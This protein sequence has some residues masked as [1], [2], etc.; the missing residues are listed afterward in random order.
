MS[1]KLTTLDFIERA[2]EAHGD[3]YDYSK[4]IY[5][6]AKSKLIIICP[7]HGEFEQD[8]YSHTKGSGCPNCKSK[9]LSEA[10]LLSQNEII[11]KF[12]AAHG[13]RYDYSQVNYLGAKEKVT[14]I[15][16][17]HGPFQQLPRSHARGRSCPKCKGGVAI[18][19]HEFIRRSRLAH[20]DFYDY[21]LVNYKRSANKVT[22]ICPEH[23]PF[24]Q[25]ASSHMQG[26][27][28]AK[29]RNDKARKSTEKFI[30][31][32]RKVHGDLYDYRL[33]DYHLSSE[34]I[35]IIC[36]RH[37][38][39]TQTPNSHLRGSGCI[40]CVGLEKRSTNSFIEEA[41]DVHGDRYD[42]S[43]VDYINSYTPVS[44]ICKEHGPFEQTPSRH[45]ASV[46]GCAKCAI[47]SRTQQNSLTKEQFIAKARAVHGEKYDYSKVKYINSS[48]KVTIICPDHGPFEQTPDIHLR[49]SQCSYCAGVRRNADDF[50]KLASDVH[51]NA[52]DYS[53]VRYKDS[54]TK[55]VIICPKH[56]K[57]EQSPGNHLS[58]NG[59]P[60]CAMEHRAIALRKWATAE[61]F[62]EAAKAV[63]GNQYDYSEVE[64]ID[65]KTN[66]LIRCPE[67]GAFEQLPSVHIRGSKC[68]A[69][70][71]VRKKST[72]EFIKEAR[73]LHGDFY[74]YS[75]TEY[76]SAH[77]KVIIHCPDHGYIEQIARDHLKSK[78]QCCSET[79]F[80][81][82]KPAWLYYLK[83]NQDSEPSLYKIGITNKS[84]NERFHA[85]DLSKIE[86]VETVQFE[87]GREAFDLEQLYLKE[88]QNFAYHGPDVL[89]SG[90]TELF[91]CDVLG[92]DKSS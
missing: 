34:K 27:G 86:V 16:P 24:D 36:P 45:L 2:R 83:I 6:S 18:D 54:E 32:A 23:G 84:V 76:I 66:V 87:S 25:I 91:T 38:A 81:Y 56:G 1:R 9:K 75:L 22:I 3:R 78:P 51:D 82:S 65:T 42:Y 60:A 19:Q 58:G 92:L 72:D 63:H 67:H 41:K 90:N 74:D 46:I 26:R 43:Q 30:E 11:D 49:G 80:N 88:Y 85:Q 48:I 47:N 15:C 5:K 53:L 17:E 33:V 73:K 62:I 79:G 70:S 71:G 44:I 40:K 7:E 55:I 28:C 89:E 14:I 20:G 10:N 37:G 39:F 61:E 12:H 13:D 57:F 4:S 52:Y 50:I 31:D 29:C 8:A 77:T 64:Y 69:C 35:F 68:P 59:C 21:S